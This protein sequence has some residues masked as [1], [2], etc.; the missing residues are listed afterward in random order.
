MMAL[1]FIG[2]CPGSTG[3]GIKT[4]TLA[5]VLAAARRGLQRRN[6]VEMCRRTVPGET[7]QKAIAVVVLSSAAVFA[8][9]LALLATER[10]PFE[11]VLF[12]TISA[13]GTVGLSAGITGSLTVGGKAW[14]ALLMLIGRLGPLTVAF[15]FLRPGKTVNYRHAEESI[16][17]G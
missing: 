8:V 3:G 14:I 9:G 11:K 1:M 2:A 12:E 7:I 10:L 13:F 5:V 6:E 17:I 16:M 4:T 15:A